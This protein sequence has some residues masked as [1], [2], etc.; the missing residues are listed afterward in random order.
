MTWDEIGFEIQVGIQL[1]HNEKVFCFLLRP[2]TPPTRRGLQV[3]LPLKELS[4]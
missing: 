3:A 1:L 4:I 2:L